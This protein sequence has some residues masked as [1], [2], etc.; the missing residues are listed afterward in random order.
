[1]LSVTCS[2]GK[3]AHAEDNMAGQAG[4]CMKC[5]QLIYFPTPK[6]KAPVLVGA[7][8]GSSEP[9]AAADEPTSAPAAEESA[10]APQAPARLPCERYYWVFLFALT[11]LVLILFDTNKETPL[12]RIERTLKA[13]PELKHRVHEILESEDGTLEELFSVLPDHRID[14]RAMLPRESQQHWMFALWS[15]IAFFVVGIVLS[16]RVASPWVLPVIGLF[17]S[18]V[19]VAFLF[20]LQDYLGHGYELALQAERSFLANLLGFIFYVGLGEELSKALPVFF[21]VRTQKKATWRGACLWG[22]ASGIGFGI[23]EGI[24]YSADQYNGVAGLEAYLTRFA[25][26]VA[27]HAL[28]SASVGITIFHSRHMINRLLGTMM[29]ERWRWS[30][31]ALPLL[32]V[33]GI[34]MTLHG[35]YDTFLTQDMIPL[36]LLV[37]LISFV[38]LGWQIETS[39]EKEMA[40]LAAAAA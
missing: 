10:S 18:T 31:V 22:L 11:P 26:C 2:C 34:A 3:V 36:A 5:N 30:E 20:L 13:H 16:W 14:D 39:R 12:Q 1:M 24:V 17:T 21:Y 33:L 27:L 23:G 15:G 7:G 25:A 4:L 37:A 40:A 9:P 35:L 29:Y 32:Q 8:V 38:W 28:W 6:Q 19:G